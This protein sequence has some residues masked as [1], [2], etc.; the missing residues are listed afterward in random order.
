MPKC[1]VCT[2]P[3]FQAIDQ[4]LLAGNGTLAALSRQYGPSPSALHR[5]K[6]HLQE[7]IFEARRCLDHNLRQGYLFKLNQTLA[8][9]EAASAKAQ[10]A[11]NVDQVFKGARV[12]NRLIRDLSKME[13]TWDTNTV[14]RLMASTQWQSQDCL[15]P[16]EPE[17]LAA[18]HKILA[19]A[20]FHP[21]PEPTPDLDAEDDDNLDRVEPKSPALSS[22]SPEILAALHP[23][24]LD[25][26]TQP[27]NPAAPPRRQR[28][29]SAKSAPKTAARK[30]NNQPNQIDKPYTK[31]TRKNAR[32]A[33]PAASPQ[34]PCHPLE[35]RNSELGTQNSELETP[36]HESLFDRLR[37]KWAQT[38]PASG[39]SC[40][41]EKFY[42]EY[43]QA[44]E[45]AGLPDPP[46]LPEDPQS[47]P[48]SVLNPCAAPP[49]VLTSSASDAISAHRSASPSELGT[50]DSELSFPDP[51][52][53]PDSTMTM[54]KEDYDR[55]C[56]RPDPNPPDP[57]KPLN[58][59]THPADYLFALTHGYRRD[60]PPKHIPDRRWEE[61]FGNPRKFQGTY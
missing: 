26:L 1:T 58:P 12:K 7:K 9:V 41:S 31:N 50:Q 33:P 35:T 4:A 38:A 21:C 30:H 32:L 22:L 3:D 20:L 25:T 36:P 10:A 11:D 60:N 40:D 46:A 24:L 17:F 47:A 55:F 59:L 15:L 52:C 53:H 56:P 42:E 57:D 27:P 37:R 8:E 6:K 14:Y 54:T 13:T 29:I 28:E 44:K 45:A 18:G 49:A 23:D 43:L 61:D 39:Y 51:S 16:T 5:H 19:E 34:P 48:H 2:H